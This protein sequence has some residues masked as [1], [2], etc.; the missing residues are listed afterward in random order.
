M[1]TKAVNCVVLKITCYI[2]LTHGKITVL[3]QSTS[4][5]YANALM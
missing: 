4:M 5:L 3:I 2:I 1:G